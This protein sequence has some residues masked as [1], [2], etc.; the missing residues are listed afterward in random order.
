MNVLRQGLSEFRSQVASDTRQVTSQAKQRLE[1]RRHANKEEDGDHDS[2]GFELPSKKTAAEARSEPHKVVKSLAATHADADVECGKDESVHGGHIKHGGFGDSKRSG[3][4]GID[5]GL[6]EGLREMRAQVVGDVKDVA[7]EV[8]TQSV[9]DLGIQKG[10]NELKQQIK[11]DVQGGGLKELSAQVKDEIKQVAGEV[12]DAVDQHTPSIVSELRQGVSD[13]TAQIKEDVQEVTGHHAPEL[14]LRQ[15]LNDLTA[16]I[17]GDVQEVTGQHA[18]TLDLGLRQGLSDF[19]AQIKGDVKEV[20]ADTSLLT[21]DLGLQKG[22]SEFKA[23]ALGSSPGHVDEDDEDDFAAQSV[24]N[25]Q[26]NNFAEAAAAIEEEEALRIEERRL[27]ATLASIKQASQCAQEELVTLNEKLD[28]ASRE[29]KELRE[30]Q[31][32][33]VARAEA[34]ARAGVEGERMAIRKSIAEAQDRLQVAKARNAAHTA[35]LESQRASAQAQ[36]SNAV[37]TGGW[38]DPVDNLFY[39]VSTVL[40]KSRILRRAVFFQLILIYGSTWVWINR[41]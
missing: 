27:Q 16:Q 37:G 18:S 4:W 39:N 35:R 20:A 5:L 13:L 29:F 11:Q 19:T 12:Q 32:Q 38:F 41:S 36:L 10:F 17:T 31:D 1:E 3:G 22:L 23:Q 6:R 28:E 26:M 9:P 34:E 8:V 33:E 24:S 30:S 21:P 25:A 40:V 2:K 7:K 14:G 15:G